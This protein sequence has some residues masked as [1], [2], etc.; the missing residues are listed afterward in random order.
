MLNRKAIKKF[1]LS[2]LGSHF[3]SHLTLVI[4]L[5]GSFYSYHHLTD[6]ETESQRIKCLTQ[7][8]L[9]RELKAKP[10]LRHSSMD[11]HCLLHFA[12]PLKL[13]CRW[14]C[15]PSTPHLAFPGA[16]NAFH[17]LPPKNTSPAYASYC[18]RDSGPQLCHTQLHCT[19]S[20]MTENIFALSP[21][22][23]LSQSPCLL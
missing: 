6:E 8:V 22:T 13:H 12:I 3:Q 23:S 15:P 17:D 20:L 10:G 2:K 4:D 11:W 1:L 21:L 18:S 7:C 19:A 5:W 16:P 14:G 9:L